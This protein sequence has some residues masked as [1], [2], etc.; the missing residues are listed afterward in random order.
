MTS[1]DIQ[2]LVVVGAGPCGIAVGAAARRHGDVSCTI[3]DR[4]CVTQSLIAYPWYMTFF[5]TAKKL[6]IEGVP[7]TIPDSQPTRRDA[8]AYY[9]RVVE[10]HD[11]D[12]RQYEEVVGI[13]GSAGDF[14]VHTRTVHGGIESM[15][16]CRAVVVATGGFHEANEL[17]VPGEDTAKVSHWYHEPYPYWD[18]DVVVV[19]GGNSAV[20]A[21]LELFRNGARVTLVH[22]ADALD[23]GVKPWVIPDI[24]NRLDRGEIASYFGHRLT[25]IRPT[26]V[27]LRSE[28]TGEITTLR[29]DFVLAMTG[30]RANPAILV[31]LGVSV[32]AETGVPTHDP[33]TMETN[34]PGVYIAGVLAAGHN[35]NKVFIENGKEHGGRI[36]AAHTRPAATTAG[37]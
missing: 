36:V 17:G 11:L 26:E 24:T 15:T 16:R 35:A 21:A 19:G 31:E 28:H 7:F 32:D 13:E 6:E 1:N 12:V 18:Q 29:N 8:L 22:F 20:D 4:G 23:R 9:R 33:E 5:S 2:D 27:V 30:W 14:R 34:R 3:F 37:G 25:E 10:H